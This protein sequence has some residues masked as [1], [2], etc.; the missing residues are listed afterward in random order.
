MIKPVS[1]T[2]NSYGKNQQINDHF[3][4]KKLL[5]YLRSY[6]DADSMSIGEQELKNLAKMMI[7]DLANNLDSKQ[8]TSYLNALRYG[9][10][11]SYQDALNLEIPTPTTKALDNFPANAKPRYREGD[12]VKWQSP[13]NISDWGVIIG[14]FYAYAKHNCQWGICYLIWLDVN[15]PSADWVVADTAWEEDLLLIV[16]QD[17]ED[18]LPN[19]ISKSQSFHAPPGSY[20][21]N[22]PNQ[23]TTR[24][25]SQREQEL[26][27]L[28]SECQL[29]MTPKHFY[30]KWQVS[31][32]VLAMVCSRSTSTVRHWFSRGKSYRRPNKDDL[33]N[34][35]L[36]D[37]LLE[38]FERI[39]AEVFSLLCAPK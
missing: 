6:V 14:H 13:N 38:H 34:L 1:T 21:S 31:H 5:S 26:I 3:G 11:E 33:R 32:D 10:S 30:N 16:S 37:F 4:V 35:A 28:Y 27:Q 36:M 18:Y 19:L 2:S 22:N 17:L 7:E 9:D 24:K 39:P 25:L 23:P 12:S 8:V 29:A 20:K 15:S